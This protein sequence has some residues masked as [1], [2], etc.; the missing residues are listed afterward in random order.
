VALRENIRDL[1]DLQYKQNKQSELRKQFENNIYKLLKKEFNN[2]TE[3]V[4]NCKINLLIN[5]EYILHSL[6]PKGLTLYD[7]N[8]IYNKI[9]NELYKEFSY[10]NTTTE[11]QKAK[12]ELYKILE[13]YFINYGCGAY[14]I[15]LDYKLKN[16]ILKKYILNFNDKE[17]EIKQFYNKTI[18]QLQ[19]EFCNLEE[20][21][22]IPQKKQINFSYLFIT[23]LKILLFPFVLCIACALSYKP[24]KRK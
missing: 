1:K 7:A 17:I 13:N 5:K 15:L 24:S 11:Y 16:D 21:E 12:N 4:E 20:V 10:N 2:T 9:L 19:K 6:T 22:E 3:T 23:I 8:K 14:N 18:K